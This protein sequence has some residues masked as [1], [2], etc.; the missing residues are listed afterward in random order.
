M[1]LPLAEITQLLQQSLPELMAL[2]LFGSHASGTANPESDLDL[3]LLLPGK[4]D[5]LTLWQLGD[6]VAERVGYPVDLLDLRAATTVMQYQIIT[7]GRR[8]W[9]K[10]HQPALYESFILSEKTAL[11]EARAPLL[12]RIQREGTIHG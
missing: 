3:A 12:E 10:D 4:A 11:D 6:K 5:P 2:Y 1:P 8:I 9:E 7:T